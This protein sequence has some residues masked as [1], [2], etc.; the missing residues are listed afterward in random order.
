MRWKIR[1][2]CCLIFNVGYEY[3][4]VVNLPSEKVGRKLL[5]SAPYFCGFK[6]SFQAEYRLHPETKGM[7]D[8]SATVEPYGFYFNSHGGSAATAREVLGYLTIA[9]TKFGAVQ[10]SE[11]E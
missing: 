1:H 10:F 8:V 2:V 6:Q 5:E 9:C 7:P 3:K 4:L 11:L